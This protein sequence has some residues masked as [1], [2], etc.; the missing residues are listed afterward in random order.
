MAT[1]RSC[2]RRI[3]RTVVLVVVVPVFMIAAY[4]S[5]WL[6][7]SMA[8]RA[9]LLS[10]RALWRIRPVFDPIFL[11]VQMELPGSGQLFSLWWKLN[12]IGVEQHH[13]ITGQ[14]TYSYVGNSAMNLAPPNNRGAI[15]AVLPEPPPGTVPALGTVAPPPK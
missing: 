15:A 7:L 9:G 13:M 10:E 2:N 3:A 4:V 11:Y 1:N 12:P 14:T 8:G 5:S 6:T